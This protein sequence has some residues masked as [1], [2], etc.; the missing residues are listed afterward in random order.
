[1][2]LLYAHLIKNKILLFV[3]SKLEYISDVARLLLSQRLNTTP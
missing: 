3:Q 1:M 2:S